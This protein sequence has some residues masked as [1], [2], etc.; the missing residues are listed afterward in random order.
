MSKNVGTRSKDHLNQVWCI[1]F[2]KNEQIDLP[3]TTVTTIIYLLEV[4]KIQ[5]KAAGLPLPSPSF[6]II[7]HHI[8]SYTIICHHIPSR[9]IPDLSCT[10]IIPHKPSIPS[11]TL[12]DHQGRQGPSGTIGDHQEPPET[13]RDHRG[14]SGTTSDL[15]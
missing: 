14:P 10:Y 2:Q 12:I 1:L 7:Y 3:I 15:Q 6:T 9:T 5:I 13:T 11:E 4:S 8:P